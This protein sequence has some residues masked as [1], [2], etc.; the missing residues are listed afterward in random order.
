MRQSPVD[1]NLVVFLGKIT[2]W[3]NLTFNGILG[4]HGINW[5]S[6]DCGGNIRALNSGRKV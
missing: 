4:T 6:E 3:H 1:D 2:D 5:I